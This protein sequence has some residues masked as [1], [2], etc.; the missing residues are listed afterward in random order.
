MACPSA[1]QR[2]ATHEYG[3]INLSPFFTAVFK[4][5]PLQLRVL[6]PSVQD[7][8]HVNAVGTDLIDH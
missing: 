7:A 1:L 5:E 3:Q 4:R 6:L 2:L 8:Q